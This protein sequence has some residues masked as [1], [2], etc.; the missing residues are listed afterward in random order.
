MILARTASV[1]ASPDDSQ[2]RNGNGRRSSS[3]VWVTPGSG[4][5]EDL[6]TAQSPPAQVTRNPTVSQ[7]GHVV[8]QDQ[9]AGAHDRQREQPSG[10][11]PGR[12][13]RDEQEMDRRGGRRAPASHR[14]TGRRR[15][16]LGVR[17]V[18]EDA[19]PAR[20]RRAADVFDDEEHA[21]HEQTLAA[22]RTMTW[23]RASGRPVSHLVAA[24][25]SS[26]PG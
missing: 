9:R 10:P 8:G 14:R 13:D 20:S 11:G 19:D 17:G 12:V 3:E 23:S 2:V 15:G 7:A 26:S 6:A 21:Q 5:R 22:T 16:E 25:R 24:V 1:E 18:D 4:M